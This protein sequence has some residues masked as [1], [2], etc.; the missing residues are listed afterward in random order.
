LGARN[1]DYL[2][3]QLFADEFQKK[4]NLDMRE[5]P[6]ARLRMLDNIEKLRKLLTANKE[7]DL[8]VE[9]LLEDEDFSRH[10]TRV[11]FEK[12]IKPVI[13]EFGQCLSTAM[14]LSG[15]SC[16]HIQTIELIGEATRIPVIIESIKQIFRK[17]EVS[18]T[19]N[20]QDCIARGCAL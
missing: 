14:A 5:S 6:R 15:L 7:A 20:S 4:H 11:D 19:L 1:I 12:I 9:A 10:L 16:E 13:K 2:L 18:R 8:M 3:Y 17:K